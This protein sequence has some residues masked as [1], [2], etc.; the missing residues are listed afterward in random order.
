MNK[1]NIP[2]HLAI[3]MDGNG[4]WAKKRNKMRSFGHKEG[5]KRVKDITKAC[6]EIGIKYLTLYAFS[7][8]NWNR[9]KT[10]VDGLMDLLVFFLNKELKE[11]HENGVKIT[12]IGDISRLPEKPLNA[13]KNAVMLTQNNKNIQLNIALNYGSRSEIVHAIRKITSDYKDNEEKITEEVVSKYLY[14]SDIPDPDFV[15][16][17]SGEIRLSNF[18]LYQ[19]AYSEMYFTDVLWPDFNKDEL[20]KALEVFSKRKRRFGKV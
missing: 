18:L 7:T 17:T 13:V 20:Y 16:R 6:D 2:I 4:R 14:T 9:P 19:I 8:E 12:T 3:I 10:E 5:V 15:I 1:S 11:L